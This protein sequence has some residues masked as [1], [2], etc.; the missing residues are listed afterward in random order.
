MH[1]SKDQRYRSF[2]RELELFRGDI[3][4]ETDPL[5]LLAYG[6]DASFYRLVPEVAVTV[7]NEPDVVEVIRQAGAFGLPLT[8]RAAGTS[9]SGQAITDGILVRLGPGWKASHILE[10][11]EKIRLQP[12]IIGSSAN[13]SLLP[14]GKKIGPDP[15]SIDSCMIGGI[16]ANNASGMCCG[17]AQNSYQT[18]DAMRIVF[19]DGTLLD[20][21]DP[22]SRAGFA[23]KRP[24]IMNRIKALQDRVMGDEVLSGR[25]REK[26]RIKNTT[27]YSLNALIDFEDPFEIIQ[28]LMVG[29]EG[30]LG[31]IAEVTFRTVVEDPHKATSLMLFPDIRRA[32]EA[33]QALKPQPVAAVEMMDRASLRSVEGKAGMPDYLKNLSP[34]ACALLVETRAST[35]D[36]LKNQVGST[37]EA[38]GAIPLVRELSFTHVPEEFTKLWNIRKGLFPA[39]G[40]VRKTGTTVIIEDVAFPME[41]L[42]RATLELQSLLEKYRYSE[43][44]I[45][46]HA[47][48]GN[49]HFVFTQDFN[50]GEEVDRYKRFMDDIVTMVVDRYD[51]SLKA[52]HGTGRNMAPFVEKEWGR[53]AFQLMKEIKKIFDPDSILNPGVIINPDPE[54]HIKDLKPLPPANPDVDK[55]IE[56]GF[57]EPVCP[58]KNITFT[59]RQRI[60]SYREI[61]RL[62]AT[63][64]DEKRRKALEKAYDYPGNQTCAADGLC[65]TRCPVSIDTA[66]LTKFLRKEAVTPMAEYAAEK[67]GSN[68]N[69]VARGLRWT[70]KAADTSHRI[71]GTHAMD[72]AADTLHRASG[73]RAPLWNREMPTRAV[74]V[75]PATAGGTGG[76]LEVVYFPSCISRTMGPSRKDQEMRPLPGVTLSVLRKGGCRVFFADN[77]EQLC[78]GQPF[79]S[80]GFDKQADRKLRELEASLLAVSRDGEIPI[81]CDTSPCL[82]RMQQGLDKRLKLYEPVLFVH[83]FLMNR[84]R[85]LKI[86]GPIS[87][88][89]TCTARKMDLE[90]PFRE[91]AE[92]CAQKVVVPDDIFCCGFAG[93]RGFSVPELNAS[94]LSGLR[95][96]TIGCE[97]GY[98]TSRGC[99]IGLSL[100]GG[101]SYRSIFYLVDRCTVAV[102]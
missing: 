7:R 86:P 82:Y 37:I 36:L 2:L 24:D 79:E 93:D 80:K 19:S 11:A 83:Q 35:A 66:K 21:G 88:H 96:A 71:L 102:K 55:C 94:A 89:T 34:S 78:C 91:L 58:S 62:A 9:L 46:G 72:T 73:G 92:A 69:R 95:E 4:V 64:T 53:D 12:G 84:L 67:I 76:D 68:F 52:E 74:A 1:G 99:E 22:E 42:D 10:D 90:V 59:P 40:A 63:G 5:H 23:V 29:S 32:C 85:F 45:F 33:V 97:S 54:A 16:V 70:L 48:E 60:T 43:A 81:L 101:I 98:S 13:R 75:D 6:T 28:H 27:G 100:H 39:V 17:V 14:F 30:T 41:A 15:A 50:R 31:F 51:G 65:A 56:C 26:F 18:L 57:C 25:I 87:L 77:M 49:L 3:P 8:F 44:I 47:L 20:T 61:R 38:V